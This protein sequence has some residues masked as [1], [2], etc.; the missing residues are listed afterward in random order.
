MTKEI[1][2]LSSLYQRTKKEFKEI[3]TE[4]ADMELDQL[5]TALSSIKRYF[6]ALLEIIPKDISLYIGNRLQ[7]RLEKTF[8]YDTEKE[9]NHKISLVLIEDRYAF[10]KHSV[11]DREYEGL[12]FGYGDE[13][14]TFIQ[15]DTL[16]YL[17]ANWKEIRKLTEQGIASELRSM[18]NRQLDTIFNKIQF[19]HTMKNWR[20]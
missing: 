3:K 2:A 16:E 6:D 4:Y 18:I 11:L 13:I 1:H 12:S 19:L 5:D 17:T 20:I 15:T 7:I 10:Q 9:R 14:T 8:F